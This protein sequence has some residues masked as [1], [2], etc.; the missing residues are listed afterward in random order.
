MRLFLPH[1]DIVG[2]YAATGDGLTTSSITGSL[3][4]L[5]ESFLWFHSTSLVALSRIVD[6]FVD[7]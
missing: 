6:N 2:P 4:G 7:F 3:H 1:F 5:Y